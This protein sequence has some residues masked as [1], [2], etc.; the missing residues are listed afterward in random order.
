M[1][2]AFPP[3]SRP[4]DGFTIKRAIYRGGFG[5]VY[6]GLSDSGREVALK[7][8]Q[9]NSDIELRG[10]QQCLNLSHP[11]LVTIFD[12]RQDESGDHW[13]IMEYIAG[14]T[15]DQ[16]LRRYPQGMPVEQVRHWLQGIAGGT[17]FLHQRGLVHRDLKPA[18]IFLDG[19]TVK[20]GDVG[21]SKFLAPSAKSAHTQSV[22]TVYYMAPEVAK[23]RYGKGVDVY[24]AGIILYEMLTGN[25]P[26]EGESTGEILMKHLTELPDLSRLPPRLQQVVGK[27]LHKDAAQRYASLIELENAFVAAVTGKEP[28][29]S[30]PITNSLGAGKQESGPAKKHPFDR[31]F[32]L[33]HVAVWVAMIFL[34]T[35]AV[36][37]MVPLAILAGVAFAGY[38]GGSLSNRYLLKTTGT[39]LLAWSCFGLGAISG[40]VSLRFPHRPPDWNEGALVLQLMAAAFVAA[41]LWVKIRGQRAALPL[42]VQG[43]P[44]ERKVDARPRQPRLQ[45]TAAFLAVPFCGLL[46]GVFWMLM[47]NAFHNV[48]A[49]GSLNV[50]GVGY[51]LAVSILAA[52]G[53]LACSGNSLRNR[54]SGMQRLIAGVVVGGLA[55]SLIS[56]LMLDDGF[57]AGGARQTALFRH[58]GRFPLQTSDG[59][60]TLGFC[61][62]FGTFF[63]MR[64]WRSL[65][66]PLRRS[67][68][69]IGAVIKTAFI[70]WLIT[71]VFVFPTGVAVSWGTL[72]ACTLQLASPWNPEKRNGEA[73]N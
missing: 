39:S 72:L 27:A 24:A 34:L 70:A 36:P 19:T 38:R 62:F 10:V 49:D 33:P 56:F 17:E 51:F 61:L 43:L 42:A 37:M 23:G 30:L 41:G 52:W 15:L 20:I 26:F 32:S 13:I 22:G 28:A 57:L 12:V 3:E 7:L 68:F 64:N 8:L 14:D 58:L 53:I 21:L 55:S 6:Y 25:V 54:S 67:Q 31:P 1:K 11:N 60:T 16:V 5:E 40:L 73:V 48:N 2:F 35:H 50:V 9:N 47:P 46:T 45:S 59:P 29:V 63:C 65:T 69:R 18:N 71:K 66:N 4:L 44:V